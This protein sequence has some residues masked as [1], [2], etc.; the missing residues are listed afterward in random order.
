MGRTNNDWLRLV[1]DAIANSA[2]SDGAP[3]ALHS[4]SVAVTSVAV[5]LPSIAL[6]KGVTLRLPSDAAVSVVF[7]GNDTV[8]AENGYPL[9]PGDSIE[10]AIASLGDVWAIAPVDAYSAVPLYWVA[11]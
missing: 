4:G 2:L 6:K 11:S 3:T 8:L 10:I 7:V 1:Y 5:S 9:Y